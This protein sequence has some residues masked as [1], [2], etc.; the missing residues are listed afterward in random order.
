MAANFHNIIVESYAK[1]YIDDL[2][3]PSEGNGW[4]IRALNMHSRNLAVRFTL[5]I[6]FWVKR[7]ANQV[8]HALTKVASSLSPFLV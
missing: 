2:S 6:F 5:C 3:V 1:V 7:G 4:K 8:A